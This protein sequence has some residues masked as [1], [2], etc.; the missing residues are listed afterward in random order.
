MAEE[1]FVPKLGQTMEQ[2]ILVR[3]LVEDGSKVD[4]GQE[5]MEVETDKAIFSVEANTKGYIHFG[6]FKE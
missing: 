2:V 6:P 5:V 3:W 4:V 1:F